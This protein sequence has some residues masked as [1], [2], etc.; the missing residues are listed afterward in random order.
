MQCF[1]TQLG[2]EA[3]LINRSFN[4]VSYNRLAR[5]IIRL[6]IKKHILR[7]PNIYILETVFKSHYRKT[8]EL[9]TRDF[10]QTYLNPRTELITTSK[11]LSKTVSKL[12]LDAIIVGSD[13]VWRAQYA[14]N[15]EDYFLG[16]LPPDAT[17]R[18]ISYG[19]SFGTPTTDFTREQSQ[20]CSALIKQFD[21]ISV[22]EKSGVNICRTIFGVRALHV[23]DPTLL[24]GASEYQRFFKEKPEEATKGTLF[25]YILDQQKEK[26]NA[27][28][29]IAA[30][31]N[32]EINIIEYIPEDSRKSLKERIAPPVEQW[33]EQLYKSHYVFSDSYHACLFSIIFE[34][35]FIIYSNDKRG[36]AR[37]DSLLDLFQL[38][39]RRIKNSSE[40]NREKIHS[41]LNWKRIQILLKQ[42]QKKASRFL[43]NSLTSR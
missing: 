2:Y 25:V 43:I 32:L 27:A 37:F 24:L 34:K 38:E 13:Q 15:I 18:R 20:R 7:Q 17:A 39:E 11:M 31:L 41:K 4:K 23:I 8:V 28:K 10:I 40:L 42:E 29:I 12:N 22:R 35:P 9:N 36:T 6:F 26:L 5:R 21:A 33:L 1:L 16:F 30:E 19:A 3:I 14:P